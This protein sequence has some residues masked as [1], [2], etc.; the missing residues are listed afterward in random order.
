MIQHIQKELKSHT[1]D[2]LVLVSASTMFLLFLR[3][4]RGERAESMLTLLIFV[5]FY[6]MW[7]LMHHTK[8]RT[9]HAKSMLEYIVISF[10]VLVLCIVAFQ[11]V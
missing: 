7:G 6:I 4:Y 8:A 10:I 11:L 5:S 2:Y 9:I 3:L 1:I